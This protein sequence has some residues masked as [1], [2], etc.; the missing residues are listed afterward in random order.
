MGVLIT[1]G[2]FVGTFAIPQNVYSDLDS[3]I[4]K[5]EEGYLID[6]LGA[7]FYTAFKA[8]LTNK[9]PVSQ[10]FLNIYNSFNEDYSNRIVKSKGMKEMLKGFIY[11]HYMTESQYKATMQGLVVNSADTS[12]NMSPGNLFNYIN[13]SVVS[14]KAIQDYI[15]RLHPSDYSDIVFNGICKEYSIPFF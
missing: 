1:T 10:R 2:D 3:Y 5:Y 4:T 14:Y 8:N 15:K 9:V 11:F 6:L 13:D 12:R 7:A